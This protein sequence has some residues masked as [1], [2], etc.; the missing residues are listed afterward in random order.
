[1]TFSYNA[2]AMFGQSSTEIADHAKSLLASLVQERGVG[3]TAYNKGRS[4]VDVDVVLGDSPF[5]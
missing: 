2:D 1:M 5:F 3:D 4:E